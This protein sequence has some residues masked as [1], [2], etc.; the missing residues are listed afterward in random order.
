MELGLVGGPV[1]GVK[2][3][4]FGVVLAW[5]RALGEIQGEDCYPRGGEA[6]PEAAL[7]E[8]ERVQELAGGDGRG[9]VERFA[10]ELV[11]L[12]N[13]GGV[14]GEEQVAWC[15]FHGSSSTSWRRARLA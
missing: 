1:G 8:E 2:R 4:G 3:G 11:E 9:V 15:L 7:R 10:A 14:M 5:G 6:E 12:R 13:R